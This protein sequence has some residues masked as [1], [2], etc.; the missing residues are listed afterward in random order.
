MSTR[1]LWISTV[2]AGS[3]WREETHTKHTQSYYADRSSSPSPPQGLWSPKV[4]LLFIAI[5]TRPLESCKGPATLHHRRRRKRASESCKGPAGPPAAGYSS[6][7]RSTNALA[8]RLVTGSQSPTGSLL[9][10]PP[11]TIVS[12]APTCVWY[13][14]AHSTATPR[15]DHNGH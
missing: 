5:A 11:N 14:G 9:C 2:T 4:R 7:S 3:C 10:P 12:D 15:G 1:C 8:M 6:K 13:T